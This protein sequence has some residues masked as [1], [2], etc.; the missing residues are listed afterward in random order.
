MKDDV[1]K[2]LSTVPDL[3]GVYFFKTSKEKILYVGKAKSLKRRLKSYFHGQSSLDVRK[4]SMVNMADDFSFVVTDNE[5]EALALESNFIKQYKPRFNIVLRD[6]KNYPYLR[7]TVQEE[8]PLIEIVRKFSNDGAVYFGP[9]VSSRNMRETLD[10][11][12]KHFSV[13]TC[14]YNLNYITRPCLQYQ[15]GNCGAP[16][17]GLVRREDYMSSVNEVLDFLSGRN[18]DLLQ[19]LTIKMQSLSDS[20]M[21][22]EAIKVRNRIGAINRALEMQKVVSPE[23]GDIDVIGFYTSG[24]EGVFNLFFI[25][26]GIMTG[27]KDFFIKDKKEL[28]YKEILSNFI[29]LFY[30]KELM[31]P[32]EIIVRERPAN[33]ALLKKWF[34]LKHKTALKVIIPRDSI[35][36]DILLMAEDNARTAYNLK[37]NISDIDII[38][39]LKTKLSLK[40]LPR[41]IGA[42]DISTLSGSESV[43]AFIYWKEGKFIKEFY[44]RIKIKTVSGIDDYAMM[45]EAVSRVVNN[46]NDD[47]P[48]LIVI[49]GG[50]GQLDAALRSFK[51]SA[52]DMDGAMLISV[53][54][55]PDRVYLPGVKDA[56]DI[57]DGQ[58]SSFLLKK[59][60]DE[61]HRFAI[62]YHRKVR[63]KRLTESPLEKI[64]GISVRRRIELL[65]RFGS[66][67][68]IRDASVEEVA[69]IKG[70][71]R[72]LA[73]R[74]LAELKR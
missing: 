60:R 10:F 53:A 22:E 8:W 47:L 62:S 68:G 13:R 6:D 43:G 33:L 32:A 64:R 28:P 65:R 20:L 58:P 18:R 25:R 59:I 15:I 30:N 72:G 4:S 14:K 74:V 73:E 3:P 46:L 51:D 5:V 48:D 49:D 37:K 12:R 67:D 16:C 44:R 17:V 70:F 11:V 50:K 27:V 19:R 7:I 40:V 69:S 57:E 2:K 56:I 24:S 55:R 31:P 1:I 36:Q 45:E 71:T 66:L 52:G 63:D 42:F 39:E 35:E 61:V 29:E 9:Y 38:K 54:K 26:N 34:R 41:S 21:F 23:L